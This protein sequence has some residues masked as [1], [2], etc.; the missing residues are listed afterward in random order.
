MVWLCGGSQA[1]VAQIG[2][3]AEIRLVEGGA[4]WTTTKSGD[5]EMAVSYAT[6][7]TIDPKLSSDAM[8]SV[9]ERFRRNM[10]SPT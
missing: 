10:A 6:S 1:A 7:D 4:H 3:T 9:T 8:P 5:Y 2:V